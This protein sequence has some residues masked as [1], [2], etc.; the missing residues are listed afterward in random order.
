MRSNRKKTTTEFIA[1]AS[2]M[3]NNKFDYSKVEY[4]TN[5]GRVIII[6]PEHGEF[7]QQVSS[8]LKGFGCSECSG[9]KRLTTTEFIS[10]AIN[11][12]NG[13]YD[14]SKVKYVNARKPVTIICPE[15]GEF[16]QSPS[17][18]LLG[19]NCMTCFLETQ[20]KGLNEFI[21]DAIEIHGDK[22]DYSKVEYKTN[23][24]KVTIICPEHGE[25]EQAARGHIKGYGCYKC[26]V[27]KRRK[28]TEEFI[29][30]SNMIHDNYY[31]YSKSKYVDA[32]SKVVIICPVHG[33]FEQAPSNHATG[34]G[35]NPCSSIR[36][37]ESFTDDTETFIGKAK[38]KHGNVY[39][40]SLVEYVN[41][42]TRVRI[43]CP[44]H[45][46][47]EQL[48]SNHKCGAGCPTCN[49][50]IG[51][52][53][54]RKILLDTQISFIPEHRFNDCRNMHPLPFDFYL[55]ELNVCI[56]YDGIQHYEPIKHFGGEEALTEI[57]KRDKIKT[58][59]CNDNDITLLRIRYDEDVSSK[60]QP[61]LAGE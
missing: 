53:E 11:V 35:C 10:K 1:E 15:H 59:Y 5:K 26:G 34:N 50:S 44:E 60:L 2:N 47:F 43:I 31:D 37:G 36:V 45:G 30:E 20:R 7:E 29:S 55:P 8:H 4:K 46:E 52:S 9:L 33:E 3:H 27:I 25:F 57:K 23:K 19:Q 38:I 49:N 56:E 17:N 61:I 24:D 58:N 54:I 39:D 12:H 41:N 51:E 28:T 18:H 40:Y 22:Y 21:S 32:Y 48:P 42:S 14:Y 13:F 6:C 16:N